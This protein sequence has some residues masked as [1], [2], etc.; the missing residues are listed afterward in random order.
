MYDQCYSKL[1]CELVDLVY[2]M[3]GNVRRDFKCSVTHLVANV[4]GGEKY[5][6]SLYLFFYQTCSTHI[7]PVWLILKA[8]K[9][10]NKIYF[11][12]VSYIFF[13]KLYHVTNL[14]NKEQTRIEGK[15]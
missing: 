6:V 12:K 14:K 13:S 2:Y 11:C 3:A 10:N 7:L 4:I 15:Q 8:P 9:S 5:D 1:Q